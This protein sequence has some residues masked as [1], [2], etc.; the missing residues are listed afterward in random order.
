MRGLTGAA[1]ARMVFTK[2]EKTTL[3]FDLGL[4][5]STTRSQLREAID[6][7]EVDS[8]MVPFVRSMEMFTAL[9]PPVSE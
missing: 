8:Y 2:V 4:F 5:I 3:V 7:K 1:L 9:V 6:E